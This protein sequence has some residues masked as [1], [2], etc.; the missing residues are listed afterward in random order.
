MKPWITL[1]KLFLKMLKLIL[2]LSTAKL[3]GGF[4]VELN[5]I[6]AFLRGSL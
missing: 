1:E 3:S 2:V 6:R 4:T 5:G